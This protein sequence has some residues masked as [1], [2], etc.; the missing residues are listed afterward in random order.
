MS[1]F[2]RAT[3][4]SQLKEWRHGQAGAERLAAAILHLDGF[5]NIDPQAP[6]GGPDDRKDIL[7]AKGNSSY[8]GAAYFPTTDKS[9]VDIKDKFEHDLEGP[10]RHNR[11]G[12]IFV[13][14]QKI[15]LA[16]R[17]SLE[18]SAIARGKLAILYHRERMRG[19]LD[20]PSGYGVR[21]EFLRIPM[22][23]SEQ[24]AYFASS[25]NRLEYALERHSREIR[26][27]ARRI[28]F[29]HAGQKFAAQTIYRLATRLG[30]DVPPPPSGPDV[31][32]AMLIE[33]RQEASP[34][35]ASLSRALLLYVH[36][37]VCADMPFGLLGKLRHLT[38]WLGVPDADRE[39]AEFVPPPPEEVPEKLE[40]L[41]DSWNRRYAELVAS[42][43]DEKLEALARFHHGLL[44]IHPFMDGNGRVARSILM[45]QC[46]DILGRVEPGLL[47]KGT[48]Y[49]QA[50]KDADGDDFES[51]KELIQK[52]VSG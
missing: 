7:C 5:E 50:L 42:G 20:S 24:F 16:D 9:F 43:E 23:E 3:T 33:G 47:D 8:V 30:E 31:P 26:N 19:L 44:V 10:V 39:H 14:N 48:Q 1:D 21:L 38:V 34:M 45:Q 12:L 32:P 15:G 6:L 46:I 4:E 25:G 40:A 17:A 2:P 35:S 27:L 36:R 22:N 49:Y 52:A 28:E 37:T 13:T 11:Q 41:L 51:L 18:Q 29:M